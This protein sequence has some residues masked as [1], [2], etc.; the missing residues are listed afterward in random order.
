[1]EY[2]LQRHC[3]CGHAGFPLPV[4]LAS[5]PIRSI[6]ETPHDPE[7]DASNEHLSPR[8]RDEYPPRN[9]VQESPA[10]GDERMNSPQ[11]RARRPRSARFRI[12]RGRRGS[13]NDEESEPGA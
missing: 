1:M 12:Q 3:S 2:A 4:R 5:R 13:T 8:S 10:H 11:G 6:L 7:P 9:S